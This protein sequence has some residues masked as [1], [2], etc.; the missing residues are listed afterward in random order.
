LPAGIAGLLNAILKAAP[1]QKRDAARQAIVLHEVFGP[2]RSRR[3]HRA[4]A[5]AF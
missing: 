3:P 4:G 5:R 1:E 2:P